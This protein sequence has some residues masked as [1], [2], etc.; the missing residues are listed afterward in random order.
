MTM[1]NDETTTTSGT[2]VGLFHNQADAERAIQRLKKEGFS[3][4]QIGVAIKD[5]ERQ[6]DLL[7]GT[8]TQAAEGAATGAIGGGVLGGVIGLLA[9]VGALAIPGVGP[10]IAGGTLASTLA[11]AGIGAAAGGLLGALVGMG[12]P[13]EDAQ[14]FDKGFRAGGTLVTVNAGAR[15]DEARNCLYESG[16]DLGSM[17]RGMSAEARTGSWNRSS[18]EGTQNI[19]LREEELR[20]EKQRVQAGE[21]RL[22]KEVVQE[23]R[24]IEVPVTREEVVIERRP[25]AQGREASGRIDENEEIRIPLMEEEVRVEK[26]PVVREEV[27]VKKR[28]VQGIEEVSDTVRREEARIEQT[29]EA[30]VQGQTEAWR[31]NERRYRHDSSYHGPER[32]L[33]R[34]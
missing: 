14:H 28:Q 22:R 6:Q 1:R 8:G 15:A 25:A 13:E 12:V 29:G 34:V 31:G 10:I 3:E 5:R 20:A 2:V 21:V 9:G 16:A 23:E 32:R 17:G 30:R 18:E 33:S 7:E 4:S 11:G 19:E 24:T 27:S 26:T